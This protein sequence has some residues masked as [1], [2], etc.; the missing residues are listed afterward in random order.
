MSELQ[1]GYLENDFYLNYKIGPAFSSIGETGAVHPKILF[2][3]S[4]IV[5]EYDALW[6]S[7]SAYSSSRLH[8]DSGACD[9]Y[10]FYTEFGATFEFR[11]TGRFSLFTDV[12]GTLQ[13]LFDHGAGDY[14]YLRY[15]EFSP[16]LKVDLADFSRIISGVSIP[17]NQEMSVQM[18]K[19]VFL[20][21]QT[22]FGPSWGGS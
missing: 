19:Q 3:F 6:R 8:S 13:Y 1:I 17:Y 16:G 2:G 9:A 14:T 12:S 4:R 18:P 21:L 20:K 22:S 7:Q 10:R 11:L 15:A 5:A